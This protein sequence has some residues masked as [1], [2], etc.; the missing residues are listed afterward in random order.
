MT[1][2]IQ[3]QGHC[4]RAFRAVRDA[5][6]RNFE[7]P[8]EVGAATSV[9]VN[10]KT[11]VDIWAGHGDAERSRP[12]QR[13]T[14][15]MVMSSSKGIVST[16]A[17]RLVERGA[18]D[19]DAPVAAYWPEF[20]Q[21]GKDRLPVRYLL[22]HQAG[23]PAV[24]QRLPAGSTIN[25]K[26]MT[27][28]LAAQAPIWKP[29]DAHGY[30]ALSWGWLVGEVIRRVTG[31]TIGQVI[32]EEIA[33]PLGVEFL[34]GFGPEYDSRVADLIEPPAAPEGVMDLIAS[35]LEDFD[36][37]LARAFVPVHLVPEYGYNSRPVRAAEIPAINGHS[38]ARSL[39]KIYA[40]LIGE[41]P[42]NGVRLLGPDALARA[43]ELQTDGVDQV[44]NKRINYGLGF[45]K[46]HQVPGSP[47]GPSTFGHWGYGGSVGLADPDAKLGFGYV[48]NRLGIGDFTLFS[49]SIDKRSPE[50]DPRAANILEAV[51]R[52]L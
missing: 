5:F 16:L 6:E 18:L 40:A 44:M 13:D 10:G 8:G 42:P 49:K 45:M 52:S 50:P 28:T 34:M 32:I 27:D 29:G 26:L 36:S 3:V 38:N 22:C 47:A 48:L 12:W 46:A 23:L 9:V 51:Y 24:D 37:L 14:L 43:T 39:A 41:V 30:H 7:D 17:H 19:L 20:A 4:D 2:P 15:V 31:K 35:I 21:N 11:V 33:E 25:W 1:D